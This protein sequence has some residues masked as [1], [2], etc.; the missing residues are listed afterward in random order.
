MIAW[1]RMKLDSTVFCAVGIHRAC[2]GWCYEKDDTP[3][4][5]RCHC[6]RIEVAAC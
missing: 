2:E 5:C 6:H 1:L 4:A 3:S